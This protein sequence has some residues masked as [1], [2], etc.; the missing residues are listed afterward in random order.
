MGKVGAI[1]GVLHK[2]TPEGRDVALKVLKGNKKNLKSNIFGFTELLEKTSKN[3]RINILQKELIN[4]NETVRSV[5]KNGLNSYAA[6][7]NKSIN[8]SDFFD[9]I[10]LSNDTVTKNY[11]QKGIELL[12]ENF[13]DKKQKLLKF[14]QTH[15][16]T[17]KEL[18]KILN[19]T[20][21]PEVMYRYLR[22]MSDNIYNC[23][24]AKLE[25]M[26]KQI[27]PNPQEQ[28]RQVYRNFEVL[29]E[30]INTSQKTAEMIFDFQKILLKPTKDLKV[31]NIEKTLKEQFNLHYV[32]LDN[33]KDAEK[34]LETAKIAAKNNVPLPDILIV[35]PYLNHSLKGQNFVCK[36]GRRMVLINSAD[37][38]K[39]IKNAVEKS[40]PGK[41]VKDAY[42][43]YKQ[44]MLMD[45][46]ATTSPLH[47]YLHE[48]VHS[49]N[50]L[51]YIGKKIPGNYKDTVE[52]LSG[53]AKMTLNHANEE[54]RTELRTKEILE[55]L[56]SK[57]SALLNYLS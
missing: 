16:S 40:K 38:I 43:C 3:G 31:K 44:T 33:I 1:L 25:R 37:D 30:S 5:V 39:T 29:K 48:F 53:Y 10:I 26:A 52:K 56:N 32:H 57:E 45:A 19:D 47:V 55:G 6:K 9:L 23:N 49:E 2:F 11:S 54:V 4:K 36:N 50:P 14:A 18:I 15:F 20:D 34:L 12:S 17:N 7:L 22:N 28:V 21:S 24:A 27:T 42:S 13:A 41:D 8:N 35:T 46:Y 51:S